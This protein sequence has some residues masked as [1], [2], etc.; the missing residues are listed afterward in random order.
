MFT[1]PNLAA[2]TTQRLLV[3]N[4]KPTERQGDKTYVIFVTP[5]GKEIKHLASPRVW[6]MVRGRPGPRGTHTGFDGRDKTNFVVLIGKRAG[7]GE[8]EVTAVHS[9]PHNLYTPSTKLSSLENVKDITLKIDQASGEVDIRQ[10]PAEVKT[11]HVQQILRA[12]DNTESLTPGQELVPELFC[13]VVTCVGADFVL[14]IT[15]PDA[16]VVTTLGAVSAENTEE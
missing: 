13:R 8:D 10:M 6:A 14:S 2:N 9:F 4:F 3:D 15:I 12:I 7:T 1:K 16:A 5:Q 11:T